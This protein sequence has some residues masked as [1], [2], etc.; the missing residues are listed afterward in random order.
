M[1]RNIKFNTLELK[2]VAHIPGCSPADVMVLVSK[3]KLKV[4]R[5]GQFWMFQ[6]SDVE[7]YKKQLTKK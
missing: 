3:G 7:V 6:I 5:K 2:D 4:T 1:A